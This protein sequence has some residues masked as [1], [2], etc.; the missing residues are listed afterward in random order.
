MF[1]STESS[2][3]GHGHHRH[4]Q[5]DRGRVHD[6]GGTPGVFGGTLGYP[7]NEPDADDLPG[8]P[9]SASDHDADDPS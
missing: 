8:A 4:R 5:M 6:N 1:D 3:T 9:P 7:A 2:G